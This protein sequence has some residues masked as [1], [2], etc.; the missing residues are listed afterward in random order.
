MEAQSKGAQASLWVQGP[1]KATPSRTDL[2]G[3][4]RLRE[5]HVQRIQC[6]SIHG[7]FSPPMRLE[8]GKQRNKPTDGGEDLLGVCGGPEQRDV[9]GRRG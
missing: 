4:S 2:E 3:G 5:Q 9:A 8:C 7:G 1:G 6:P